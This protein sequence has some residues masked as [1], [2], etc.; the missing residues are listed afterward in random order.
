MN[1]AANLILVGPMGAGKSS[2]GKR[3]AAHFGLVLV[4]NDEQVEQRAG[5][6]VDSIFKSEGE[7][8][9]R[10]RERAMLSEVLN[11]DGIVLATGGGTVLDGAN[12]QLLREHGFVVHLHVSVAQ[13]LAR[14]AG[15]K[16][17]P[18]LQRDDRD[19]ALHQLALLR[20]PLYAQVSD[21]RFDTGTL[22]AE[23]A[24]A[25]LTEQLEQHW[26][27]DVIS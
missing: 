25:A 24:S 27:R 16:T 21:L 15:D 18:L 17:R 7:S 5:A 20:T 11:G 2:I 14:L 6:S 3:L 8:G 19:E 23:Q 13:Q 1:P 4:D 9:F 26:R 10:V 22:S 12:R